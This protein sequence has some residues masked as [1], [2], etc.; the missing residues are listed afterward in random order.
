MARI[1]IQQLPAYSFSTA[2]A[3]RISDIN[4]G[5]H[6]GNDAML[7]II[8]E[9]RLQYLRQFGYSELNCAGTGLIMADVGIEFK[10]EMFYGDTAVVEV[11]A[12]DFS[13][14]GFD[15]YYRLS[16]N[17]ALVALAKT[18][19]VCYDYERKKLAGV[20]ALLR[21][22]LEQTASTKQ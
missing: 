12:T 3:V 8:H 18:G 15:L 1:K 9:A 7:S 2:I 20:P 10:K 6:V 13:A 19:M 21:Q 14:L 11:T 5:N 4:Y 16:T 22:Q 17:G